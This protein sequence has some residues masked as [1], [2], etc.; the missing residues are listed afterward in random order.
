MKA[1][2]ALKPA[3]AALAMTGVLL[4]SL[5]AQ[6]GR[7]CETKPVSVETLVRSLALAER[8]ARWLDARGADVVLLARRGQNLDAYGVQWSHLGYAY[9]DERAKAWRVVHKLNHCGTAESAI[10]RQG[11]AEFFSDDLYRF[12]AGVQVLSP[13][14][15]KAL[16]PLLQDNGRAT[17]LHEPRYSMVAFPWSTRYQQSNQWALETLALAMEP[18]ASDRARAQA[19]LQ[20][21]GY[22]PA[23][24]RIDA[25]KRLGARVGSAHIAFDDHPSAQRFADRIDTVTVDSVFRFV[26][27][28]GLAPPAQTVP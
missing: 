23:T 22:V 18:S 4:T 15:Q 2:P 11:L 20:F 12:E 13:E 21:K 5:P 16:R 24:L 19:W 1:V 28:A 8:T 3:L 7:G 14:A 27:S 10:Y 6:A 26:Q 9:R 17:M 25:M